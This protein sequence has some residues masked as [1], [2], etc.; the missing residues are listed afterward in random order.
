MS[1]AY[2]PRRPRTWMTEVGALPAPPPPSLLERLRR[3]PRTVRRTSRR[4]GRTG[5]FVFET[6]A[7]LTEAASRHGPGAGAP[8]RARR[9][10]WVCENL[11]T[12]LGL[13]VS[14]RGALPPEPAI[15]VAN[16]QSYTDPLCI[17]R[18]APAFPIAK[19]EVVD[20]PLLGDAMRELGLLFV[21]RG[22]AGSGARVL[23][24]SRRLLAAGAS[25]LA[26]PEGTTTMGADAL[27]FR[28]GIF[29]VATLDRIPVVPVT[30][31]YA[32]HEM[33]WVGSE[34]FATHWARTAARRR[35]PVSVTFHE[36]LLPAPG[37]DPAALAEEAR[38]VIRRALPIA[39]PPSPRTR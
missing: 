15:V 37:G 14:V 18:H 17:L 10:S 2:E 23:R 1:A 8:S 27:P 19:A 25:I 5:F 13:D 22:S 12:F 24:Q 11:C 32:S 20:W 39:D 26:F 6:I 21:V 35:N 3:G 36:P 28:R 9:L 16:H 38:Q 4:L 34:S 31:R 7:H 33:A 29:G 30:V